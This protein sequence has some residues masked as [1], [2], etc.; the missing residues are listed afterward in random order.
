MNTVARLICKDNQIEVLLISERDRY[1]S[2]SMFISVN[3]NHVYVGFSHLEKNEYQSMKHK[4]DKIVINNLESKEIKIM[5]RNSSNH[6]YCL[7]LITSRCSV[8]KE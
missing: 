6:T 7:E 2:C 5:E 3:N 8:I 4:T 1:S